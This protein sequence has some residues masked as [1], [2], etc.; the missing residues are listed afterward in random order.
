MNY[1]I[2]DNINFFD[3]LKKELNAP[4]NTSDLSG[5]LISNEV[6]INK[7]DDCCLITRQPL[8]LN[9]VT[10]T[11][12]HKF[13]YL[14]LYKE[15]VNQKIPNH[16][17]TTWLAINEI[18]CPYCRTISNK[19]LPYIDYPDVTHKK[20]VNYPIKY[21]MQLHKC[22]WTIKTGKH[23]NSKCCKG[24]YQ[25]KFGAYCEPHQKIL[26]KKDKAAIETQTAQAVIW[27]SAHEEFNKKY[28]INDLKQ[29]LRFNKLK[30]GGI[31]K[32]LII[33]LCKLDTIKYMDNTDGILV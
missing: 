17:E 23:K 21:C 32:E 10:L 13:N 6:K 12:N 8:E 15:V 27:T 30:V 7:P 2:A 5:V 29:I 28:K 31:K 1:I 11:C 19:L 16:L 9:Y 24:A 33:R 22:D 20:C 4:S 25:S 18:K 14:S 3:E 26:K